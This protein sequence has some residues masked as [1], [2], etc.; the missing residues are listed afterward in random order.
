MTIT[1]PLTPH[2]EG[3]IL[4]V[5]ATPKAAKDAIGD[6]HQDAGGKAWLR[7]RVTTAPE[8]GK[9]NKAIIKLLSKQWKIPASA[10]RVLS[11]ETARQKRLFISISYQEVLN[12]LSASR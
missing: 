12:C 6:I 5:L 7:V 9:A 2:E 10:M 1:L 11:G 4:A 8:D 3:C